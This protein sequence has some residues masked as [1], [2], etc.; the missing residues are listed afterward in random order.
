MMLE[1]D[2]AADGD[3]VER[4]Y[5]AAKGRGRIS[6]LYMVEEGPDSFVYPVPAPHPWQ[7]VK[8]CLVPALFE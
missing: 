1:S 5:L 8:R 7:L 6:V 3:Q 4:T 2:L